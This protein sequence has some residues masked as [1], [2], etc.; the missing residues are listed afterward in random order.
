MKVQTHIPDP[1]TI[2][3]T[4][5]EI[6][7]GDEYQLES[8][9]TADDS[10]MLSIIF[11]IIRWIGDFFRA[12]DGLLGDLPAFLRWFIII[13]LVALLTLL[14][15]HIIYTIRLMIKGGGKKGEF[16]FATEKMRVKPETLE[17]EAERL[18]NQKDYISA[19][20][21]LF[22]AC[23]IRLEEFEKKTYSRGMTNHQHLVHFKGTPVFDPF[24]TFVD[25]IDFKWYGEDECLEE[26]FITCK[27]AHLNI[28]KQTQGI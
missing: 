19:V 24:K 28:C 15:M 6:V 5:Q 18:S 9:A 23:L 10:I 7:Q 20:R 2:R 17:K 4:A 22:L 12:L 25:V 8:V 16:Q 11:K 26:D 3:Q 13:A 27:T 1:S 14:I 21:H